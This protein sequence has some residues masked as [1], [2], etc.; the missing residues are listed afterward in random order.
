[1]NHN[2]VCIKQS[3]TRDEQHE[4][5]CLDLAMALASFDY[6]IHLIFY[7]D[8]ICSLFDTNTESTYN[9]R[10]QALPLF[11]VNG[12]LVDEASLNARQINLSQLPNNIKP[13]TSTE[14]KQLLN[15]SLAVYTL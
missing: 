7:G 5:E 9:K 12:I 10:L 14:L 3:A 6:R 8:G 15:D 2:I 1:M 11:D 13:I 4:Y